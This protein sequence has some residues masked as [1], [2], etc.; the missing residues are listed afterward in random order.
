ME[1][2]LYRQVILDLE[3]QIKNMKPNAKLPSER[4]LLV[5]YGVSRNTVRLALQDLEERGLIYR[6][7]GKGTFVSSTFLNQPNI[8]GMYS[9]S[10]ELKRTGQK[11]S[12]ENQSLDLITPD[13][14]IAAQLN[15]KPTEKAYKLV[16]LR[17]ANNEPRIF[18]T[19]YLPEKIFPELVIDDLKS[20]PLYTVM[21][22]KYN[23]ISVMAFEDVEAVC[24]NSEESK[25]LAEE[26][27]SPSLKIFRKTINDK[28]VPVE[29]TISLA[30]GDKFVYRSRQYND[31][32]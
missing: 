24:L 17:L 25:N 29:F 32:S 31:L 23:Q 15:L 8:G 4:Q 28:N 10:E 20:K 13:K 22:E 6:L 21:K 7:H 5:K 16:R 2:P 12:T 3:K 9:F 11:A 18:S 19:S 27:G 30:R 1:K 26:V 14:N